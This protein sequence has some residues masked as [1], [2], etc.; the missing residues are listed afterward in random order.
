MFNYYGKFVHT[1]FHFF[2]HSPSLSFLSHPPNML[3]PCFLFFLYFMIHICIPCVEVVQVKDIPSL[4]LFFYFACSSPLPPSFNQ[5]WETSLFPIIFF[6]LGSL[7]IFKVT[8]ETNHVTFKLVLLIYFTEHYDLM[9]HPFSYKWLVYF[10]LWQSSTQSCVNTTF[11][12]CIH[13]LMAIWNISK[14][15]WLWIV[16]LQT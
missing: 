10:C 2:S 11:S 3:S 5:L 12:L 4:F 7:F 13:L 6:L 9:M 1:Q 15:Q 14:I 16:L 8:H